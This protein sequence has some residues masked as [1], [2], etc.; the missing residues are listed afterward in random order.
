M[1][2]D[3]I[4]AILFVKGYTMKYKKILAL[5]FFYGAIV[6]AQETN[7][8]NFTNRVNI[9][10]SYKKEVE[11]DQVNIRLNHTLIKSTAVEAQKELTLKINKALETAKAR[12][13]NA[14]D[15]I[16][17]S[18]QIS[19]SPM[20]KYANGKQIIENWRGYA[21]IIIEGKNIAAATTVASELP[22]VY[23]N[24][25]N[26]SVSAEKIQK[27]KDDVIKEAI[28]SYRTDA[29]KISENFGYK[30]Y[31]IKEVQVVYNPQEVIMPRSNSIMAMSAEISPK[32][33]PISVEPGKSIIEA[34]VSG[35][36][37]MSQ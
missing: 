21:E 33:S 5:L 14:K 4:S 26:L 13:N 24:S 35:T 29:K 18:G 9:S 28:N 37:E 31:S 8:K 3:F 32:S 15:Y 25:I 12:S 10:S 16:V 36:I 1:T 6:Q 7:Q 20:Y 19:V 2:N 34:N 17:R 30:N 23:I 22:D 27:Y 11:Q